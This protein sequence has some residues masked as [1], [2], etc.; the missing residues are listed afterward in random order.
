[1]GDRA[2]IDRALDAEVEA[3]DPRVGRLK[4]ALADPTAVEEVEALLLELGGRVHTGPVR[5]ELDGWPAALPGDLLFALSGEPTPPPWTVPAL[6]ASELVALLDGLALAGARLRLRPQ[7]PDGARL[8]RVHLDRSRRDGGRAWLPFLDEEGRYSL[9]PR[10]LAEE[11]AALF[12]GPVVID[13][14]CGCGGNAVALAR[15]G[16]RVLAIELEPDRLELARR[17]LAELG[18]SAELRLGDAR[19]LLSGMPSG[20]GL[21]LDPPWGG[22]GAQD[23]PCDWDGL[24]GVPADALVG[25][26]PIVVKAPRAFDLGSLPDRWRWSVRAHLGSPD[27]SGRRAVLAITAWTRS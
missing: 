19:A 10:D 5:L 20:C 3:D 13:A 18:L 8:P 15:R 22:P 2:A 24:V 7:L 1:M 14:F 16:L 6:R 9:S 12:P 17:N 21:F 25:F 27:A 4:A 26:A 23:L 11:Q